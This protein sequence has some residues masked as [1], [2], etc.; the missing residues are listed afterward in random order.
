MR[1]KLFSDPVRHFHDYTCELKYLPAPNF[2]HREKELMLFL[3]SL[4]QHTVTFITI[5]SS[6]N[7][8]VYEAISCSGMLFLSVFIELWISLTLYQE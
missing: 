8:F 3:R 7:V 1:N 6:E 5:F 4:I 2:W